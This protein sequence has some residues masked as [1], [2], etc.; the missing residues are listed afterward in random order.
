MLACLLVGSSSPPWCPIVEDTDT[1]TCTAQGEGECYRS[2]WHPHKRSPQGG[3]ES[4]KAAQGD[5]RGVFT[6]VVAGMTR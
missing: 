2:E 5:R 3:G 6:S 1:P 4:N